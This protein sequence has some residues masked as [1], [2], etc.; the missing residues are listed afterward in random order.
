MIGP[1]P[2]FATNR[3]DVRVADAINAH[4][5]HLRTALVRPAEIA[6]ATAY[7]NVGGY[8]LLAEELDHPVKVRLLL[9][10]EPNATIHLR[11]LDEP[12][13]HARASAVRIRRALESHDRDLAHDRD[14]LGFTYEADRSARRLVEWLRSGKV[15]VRRLHDR[16]LHG[17]AFL[18]ITDHDEGVIA[19]SSNFTFAGLATN[20]ELNLGHYQPHVVTEV[21]SWFEELWDAAEPYNLAAL[22][23]ARFEPH[24]PQLIYLR[25]L[26]ERYG[27]E[28]EEEAR[29]TTGGTI[30]LTSFQRDGLWR[31]RRILE[32]RRGVLIADEV[33]LGKTFLAGKLI[34]EAAIERRQRVLVIAPA[35]LRDGPWRRFAS[36]FNLPIE[37]RS[38]EDLIGDSRLNSTASGYVLD[39]D[40]DDYAL[41][42][43]DEAHNVRNPSTLRAEAI[44]R[45]LAGRVPKDLVLVTATPVN[46][47]LWDLY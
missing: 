16:F 43:I 24:P 39:Q 36:D 22:Y 45:L 17:K 5:A 33:G 27:P 30:H 18:A 25:M 34:E 29:S 14:L 2:E 13:S 26:W 23:E 3:G 41:V 37:L 8:S 1:K 32:G 12:A 44:R 7:F 10:A 6:V 38:F 19:G 11:R 35:T 9:G 42:V 21:R 40:P 4:L 31:A 20:I 46:N 47:S 28:I 15:E